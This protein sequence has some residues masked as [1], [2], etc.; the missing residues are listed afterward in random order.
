[1][2]KMEHGQLKFGELPVAKAFA[3]YYG[4]NENL[5][6]S[7]FQNP[8]CSLLA[9]PWDRSRSKSF[10]SKGSSDTH[11][12]WK[13]PRRILPHPIILPAHFNPRSL[14]S[15]KVK[16]SF[17]RQVLLDSSFHLHTDFISHYLISFSSDRIKY[18]IQFPGLLE[19]NCPNALFP[20]YIKV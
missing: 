6:Q 12:P 20:T 16:K 5:S 19:S 3:W 18:Q 13:A 10:R 11:S 14:L 1:M 9:F 8:L 4:G 2:M 7:Q 15:R 17:W